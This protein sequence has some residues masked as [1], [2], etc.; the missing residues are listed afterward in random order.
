MAVKGTTSAT[1]ARAGQLSAKVPT[2]GLNHVCAKKDSTSIAQIIVK[3]A[4]AHAKLATK[5][6]TTALH[7]ITI[8]WYLTDAVEPVNVKNTST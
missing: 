2:G 7:A 4:L 3:T 5:L 6:K 1:I 8:T